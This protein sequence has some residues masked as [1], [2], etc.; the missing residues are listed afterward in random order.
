MEEAPE[1]QSPNMIFV[2]PG[3]EGAGPWYDG[4]TGGLRSGVGNTRVEL[5][6]WGVPLGV[7]PNMRLQVI[8]DSAEA[9]VAQRILDWREEHPQARISIVGHSGGCGVILEALA[10]LPASTRVEQV[11]LLAPGVSDRYD[12]APALGHVSGMLHVF[13]SERDEVLPSTLLTGTY[14]NVWCDAA[15][16]VGFTSVGRLRPGLREHV[17]QYAYDPRWA[18][19][20]CGGGHFG[21]RSEAFVEYVVAPLLTP[22]PQR[23]AQQLRR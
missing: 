6:P 22:Y 17:R 3:S 14:D 23:A 2:V 18:A 16:V 7:L 20:G 21:W 12:L 15:G 9:E 11:V 1:P 13:F 8:H 4:L 5:V 19:V 10:L